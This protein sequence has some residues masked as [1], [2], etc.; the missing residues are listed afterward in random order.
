MKVGD[1]VTLSSYVTKLDS[2]F[3]F[4]DDYRVRFHDDTRPLIGM[5][6]KTTTPESVRLGYS[7]Y[8]ENE[9]VRF[10]IKWFKPK[11]PKGR[12]G[13]YGVCDY[14]YR[15]DLKFVSKST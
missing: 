4:A 13:S 10:H 6:I 11:A 15:K 12:D 2:L 7:Y 8:S 9:R 3:M 14:F 5:V 1:L